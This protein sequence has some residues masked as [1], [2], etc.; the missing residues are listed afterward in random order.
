M[1]AVIREGGRRGVG[2][3]SLD[4]RVRRRRGQVVVV[5]QSSP[6]ARDGGGRRRGARPR[7]SRDLRERMVRGGRRRS[8]RQASAATSTARRVVGP[9]PPDLERAGGAA[10]AIAAGRAAAARGARRVWSVNP[11]SEAQGAAPLGLPRIGIWRILLLLA[12]PLLSRDD[13]RKGASTS[14][15][16]TRERRGVNSGSLRVHL[17]CSNGGMIQMNDFMPVRGKLKAS[18]SALGLLFPAFTI[19]SVGSFWQICA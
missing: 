12:P 16:G 10:T 18:V 7:P 19:A 2:R 17:F 15:A 11:V 9:R 8:S 6:R 14:G 3:R 13:R 5:R 4:G 1:G